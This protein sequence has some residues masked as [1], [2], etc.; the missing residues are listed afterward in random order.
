MDGVMVYGVWVTG[1]IPFGKINGAWELL[2]AGY[3][4]I[5]GRV[6]EGMGEVG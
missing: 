6:L 3:I 5:L 2:F 4:H 1:T